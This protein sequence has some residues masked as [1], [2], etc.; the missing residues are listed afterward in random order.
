[1]RPGTWDLEQK[2]GG[3]TLATGERERQRTS[4]L[5]R[6]T[7]KLEL[8]TW[9]NALENFRTWKMRENKEDEGERARE[10]ENKERKV[11]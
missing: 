8:G 2:E 3:K 10:D 5:I 4:T 1:L 7:W 9:N 6:G 11:E